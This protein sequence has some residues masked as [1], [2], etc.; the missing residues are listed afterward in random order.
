MDL[1][2]NKMKRQ[3]VISKCK[4]YRYSLIREWNKNKGE[5]LFLMFNP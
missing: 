2:N 1:N 3:A 4:K 5:V